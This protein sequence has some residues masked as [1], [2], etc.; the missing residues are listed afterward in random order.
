M[1]IL[2]YKPTGVIEDIVAQ[3]FPVTEDFEF[4]EDAKVKP[5]DIKKL[6]NTET[7]EITER[8]PQLQRP[9]ELSNAVIAQ[10]LE[11]LEGKID[12]KAEPRLG[13]AEPQPTFNWLYLL[14]IPLA[15]GAYLL[16]KK[17]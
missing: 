6:Y 15:I 4:I 2:Y 10:K 8:P 7:K 9:S 14:M 17:I 11:E 16:G 5:G 13:V 3:P 1:Y 12:M